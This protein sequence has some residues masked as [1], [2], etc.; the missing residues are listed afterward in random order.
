MSGNFL[1]ILSN[2]KELLNKEVTFKAFF[3]MIHLNKC[4]VPVLKNFYI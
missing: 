3:S 2:S 1:D 4:K